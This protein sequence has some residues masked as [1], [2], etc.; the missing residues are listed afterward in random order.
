[1]AKVKPKPID[2]TQKILDAPIEPILQHFKITTWDVLIVGDGSGS[3]NN[4]PSGWAAVLIDR[5]TRGRRVFGGH[6]NAGSIAFA[7]AMPYIQAINW[8]DR[9]FG[10]TRLRNRPFCD[11]HVVTDSSTTANIGARANETSDF[12]SLVGGTRAVSF[13]SAYCRALLNFRYRL[14]WHWQRRESSELN[15]ICDLLSKQHRITGSGV[16]ISE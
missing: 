8:Y 1:M 5:E 7:E 12:S 4:S 15:V 13:L 11:I 10:E 16:N 3:K 9:A 6:A 2:F 14:H